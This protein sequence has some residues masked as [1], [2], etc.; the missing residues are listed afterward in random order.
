MK[1][2]F[3]KCM[4]ERRTVERG[5]LEWK[6]LSRAALTYLLMECNVPSMEWHKWG[7]K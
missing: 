5:S 2:Q 7:I 6:A 3:R 1:T 4:A